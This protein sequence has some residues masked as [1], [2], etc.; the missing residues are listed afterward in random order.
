MSTP[1]EQ[2]VSG[3]K[4]PALVFLLPVIVLG[5]ILAVTYWSILLGVA[6]VGVC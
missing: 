6:L 2:P 5:V 3:Q 4:L 1:K